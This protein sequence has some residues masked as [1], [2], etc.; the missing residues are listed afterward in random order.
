MALVLGSSGCQTFP[1][2][3]PF[4]GLHFTSKAEK[5]ETA[6]RKSLDFRMGRD[7]FDKVK[8]KL[9]DEKKYAEAEKEFKKL[10]KKYKDYPVE[11]D[12]LYLIAESQYIEKRYAYAQDSY[13]RL[14]KKYPNTRYREKSCQRL[15]TIGTI[16]LRG[17]ISE[18]EV[19]KASEQ[20]LQVNAEDIQQNPKQKEGLERKS[21]TLV[22][23][24]SDKTRPTFDTQGRALQAL[25]SVFIHDPE[26]GLAD[27]AL[28]MRAAYFIRRGNYRDADI[29]LNRLREH[30]QKSEHAKTAFF[31]GPHVKLMN[32]QGARYDSRLLGE[33]DALARGTLQL[34]PESPQTKKLEEELAMIKEQQAEREWER[35]LF[36]SKR[37]K[38]KAAGM[39][40]EL[41]IREHPRSQAAEKSRQYLTTL[42]PKYRSGFIKDYPEY[43]PIDRSFWGYSK[44]RKASPGK[45]QVEDAGNESE[46]TP[47]EEPPDEGFVNDRVADGQQV[48]R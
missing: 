31:L 45:A 10:V 7:E 8:E 37:G 16:W 47:A 20:L 3:T 26:G 34:Y 11:E 15:F 21:Y 23:N 22:P 17:D 19:T 24:F 1:V 12:S 6:R 44:K 25:N 43:E 38:V 48:I 27:D 2:K 30:F 33:A 28:M 39:Y 35:A 4:D 40:A 41:L 36:Y 29:E 18:K 14:I 13:D 9:Y 46:E 5:E 32:Y 42:D